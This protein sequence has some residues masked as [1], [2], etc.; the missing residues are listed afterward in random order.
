MQQGQRLLLTPPHPTPHPSLSKGGIGAKIL[1]IILPSTLQFCCHRGPGNC[2]SVCPPKKTAADKN[3]LYTARNSGTKVRKCFSKNVRKT[4]GKA[5][6]LSFYAGRG[7]FMKRSDFFLCLRFF[8]PSPSFIVV[9]QGKSRDFLQRAFMIVRHANQK[10]ESHPPPPM[11]RGPKE[12]A[13]PRSRHSKKEDS[14]A[15]FFPTTVFEQKY[16]R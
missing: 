15:A 6:S 1:R 4:R 11:A 5:F 16:A 9:R 13:F 14:L 3:A 8:P 2:I 10:R 7:G 12:E